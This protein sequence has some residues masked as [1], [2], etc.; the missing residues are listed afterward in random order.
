MLDARGQTDAART[1][2]PARLPVLV[3]LH[4]AHSTPGR[5]GWE[6][7]RLGHQLDVRRPHNGDRLPETLAG[8]AGA[9]IF[10]GPGSANDANPVVRAEVE[11]IKVA[12][13][14]RKPLLGICLGAQMLALHL[15]AKVAPHP[16]GWAEIGYHPIRPLDRDRLGE[17]APDHVYQW[18]REGF[19]LPS[20]ARLLASADGP[21]PIQAFGYGEGAI[22]LQFHPEIT[23]AMVGRWTVRSAH[24]LSLPGAQDRSAQLEGHMVH[25]PKVQ[26]WLAGFLPR[27]LAG[28]GFA[29]N[30]H[31]DNSAILQV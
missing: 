2:A 8:H 23:Y 15:G 27:W 4:Q 9:V 28:T 7:R 11:W 6:L 25:A 26:R 22:G 1:Q 17:D 13:R 12:L 10:G 16:N 29:A 30:Q 5:V 20:G 21:F 14:E 31:V 24:R 18:H 19:E 3:V